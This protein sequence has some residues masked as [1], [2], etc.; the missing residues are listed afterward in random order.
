[1]SS[2]RKNLINEIFQSESSFN[3]KI[4]SKNS[5][6]DFFFTLNYFRFAGNHIRLLACQVLE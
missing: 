1:M 4:Q 6:H 5:L 2:Q 3:K